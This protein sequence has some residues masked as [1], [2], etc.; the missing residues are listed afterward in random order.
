MD[1]VSFAALTMILVCS[2]LQATKQSSKNNGHRITQSNSG[3]FDFVSSLQY[4]GL[5]VSKPW[6]PHDDTQLGNV[7]QN[8]R[9]VKP[10]F[11][12]YIKRNKGSVNGTEEAVQEKVISVFDLN[13]PFDN[14]RDLLSFS[15][16][17]TAMTQQ[18]STCELVVAYDDGYSDPE[19]LEGALSLSNLKQVSTK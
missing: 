14:M 1:F 18:M 16:L 15:Y 13:K 4:G 11:T 17:I 2:C 12:K 7:S 19:V 9:R 6:N 5:F 8:H 10:K 3:A